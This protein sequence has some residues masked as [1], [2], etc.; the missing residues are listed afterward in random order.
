MELALKAGVKRLFMFHHDPD[1]NDAKV[2]A[3]FKHARQLVA[4]RKGTLDVEAAREG[5]SI[6]FHKNPSPCTIS[7]AAPLP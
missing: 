4:E 3:M 1:H 5:D 6:R 2:S 7:A